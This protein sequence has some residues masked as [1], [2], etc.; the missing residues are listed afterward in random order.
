MDRLSKRF[1]SSCSVKNPLPKRAYSQRDNVL[2]SQTLRG[3]L[4]ELRQDET[5][6]LTGNLAR[7]SGPSHQDDENNLV[8]E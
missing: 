3:Q 6:D 7:V 4:R 2:P 5:I 1:R 8:L